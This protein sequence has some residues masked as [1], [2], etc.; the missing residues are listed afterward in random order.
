MEVNRGTIEISD[1]ELRQ[2]YEEKKMAANYAQAWAFIY[3]LYMYQNGRY[4]S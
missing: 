4:K 1:A 3:F 2:F